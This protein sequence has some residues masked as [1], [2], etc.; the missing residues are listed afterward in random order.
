MMAQMPLNVSKPTLNAVSKSSI[1]I[2]HSFRGTG[3][4]LS[5][6]GPICTEFSVFGA[7]PT[8]LR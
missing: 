6:M 5:V 7:K 4:S 1:S 3:D 8:T 2:G